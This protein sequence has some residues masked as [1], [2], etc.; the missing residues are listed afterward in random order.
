MAIVV[1][2]VV[3]SSLYKATRARTKRGRM[4]IKNVKRESRWKVVG[5]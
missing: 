2:V 1:V 4:K 3:V 5:M